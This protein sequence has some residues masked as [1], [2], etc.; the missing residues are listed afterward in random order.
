MMTR[1]NL[2]RLGAVL[3]L[4]LATGTLAACSSDRDSAGRQ[5]TSGFYGGAG[6]GINWR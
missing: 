4:V 5:G 1:T 6:G 2:A 3:A